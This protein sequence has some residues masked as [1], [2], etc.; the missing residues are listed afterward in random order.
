M[1]IRDIIKV[2]KRQEDRPL[3]L[4]KKAVF[5]AG[6]ILELAHECKK[7]KGEE[8]AL[9]ILNSGKANAKFSEII[10]AQNGHVPSIEELDK[11]KADEELEKKKAA[12]EL[13]KIKAAEELAKNKLIEETNEIKKQ[14]VIVVEN[15][16]LN[17]SELL[18]KETF[19]EQNRKYI[20]KRYGKI[21]HPLST[22]KEI[23]KK[24]GVY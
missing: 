24:D 18:R 12:D 9:D 13:A 3:D 22:W 6:Q 1:E 4:E 5:L 8:V 23:L 2:L 11:I 10:K 19:N 7:G 15:P 20:I 17:V 16:I 14:E 21:S